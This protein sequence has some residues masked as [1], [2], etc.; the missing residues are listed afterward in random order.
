MAERGTHRRFLKAPEPEFIQHVKAHIKET[1]QPETLPELFQCKIAKDTI[2]RILDKIEVPR[3]KRPDGDLAPCPMCTS[4]KFLDGRLVY[5]PSLECVA[6]IGHDCADREISRQA[7]EEWERER[8]ENEELDFL[9]SAAPAVPAMLAALT[10][11][12]PVAEGAR[13]QFQR[14]RRKAASVHRD[15][16]RAIAT[17]GQLDVSEVISSEAA[18]VGP[19]GFRGSSTQT[20]T[21]SVGVLRGT[22]A[23][24]SEFDP[25]QPIDMTIARLSPLVCGSSQD[26]I[27][28]F[29]Y[30]LEPAD[31]K[32]AVAHIKE[33]GR[34]FSKVTAMLADFRDFFD[35]DNLATINAW[36]AHENSVNPV[37]VVDREVAGEREVTIKGTQAAVV[38]KPARGLWIFSDRWPEIPR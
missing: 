17:S 21:H 36:G 5:F 27:I 25:V 14:F 20:R 37:Q 7:E 24:R 30:G 8:R 33:A 18:A 11:L 10:E 6:L 19:A 2:F 9:L 15:L 12:R 1:G 16:R 4:N 3:H 26:E 23:V 22:T 38:L 31:R 13:E 28:E 35:P 29:V 32:L 34:T